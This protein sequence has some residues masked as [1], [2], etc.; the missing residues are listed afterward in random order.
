MSDPDDGHHG[1]PIRK[2]PLRSAKRGTEILLYCCRMGK[3]NFFREVSVILDWLDG[4]LDW[5]IFAVVIPIGGVGIILLSLL[6]FAW[7]FDLPTS[8]VWQVGLFHLALALLLSIT[9][10]VASRRPFS[11]SGGF[12]WF[13]IT[14][15]VLVPA[16]VFVG[17]WL[18]NGPYEGFR[19]DRI[20]N[21]VVASVSGFMLVWMSTIFPYTAVVFGRKLIRSR[22]DGVSHWATWAGCTPVIVT[23][24][25]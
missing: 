11:F 10:V 6:T 19:D 22:R 24:S 8:P 21:G 17:S 1:D 18:V 16:A 9:F 14:V 5:S 4:K 20:F 2:N 3:L 15:S 13:T 7:E 12:R 25:R 23:R